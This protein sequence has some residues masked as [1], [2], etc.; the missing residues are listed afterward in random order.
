MQTWVREYLWKPWL[1]SYPW[2]L[3]S[4][5][6]LVFLLLAWSSTIS[7]FG[8]ARLLH[9]C[10]HPG[11]MI[12]SWGKD[13]RSSQCW[14]WKWTLGLVVCELLTTNFLSIVPMCMVFEIFI[15]VNEQDE[16]KTMKWNFTCS[17]MTWVTS[18]LN[19]I[20]DFEHW[21]NVSTIFVPV[22]DG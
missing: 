21:T 19:Y 10:A 11:S 3:T 9:S 12:H 4:C 18:L 14:L 2:A 1:S 8:L 22:C 15:Y 6:P 5:S 20:I 13:Q 16:S 17:S 7:C